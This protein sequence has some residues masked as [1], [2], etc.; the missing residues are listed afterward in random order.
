MSGSTSGANSSASPAR[1]P[2]VGF[3][4]AGLIGT[5][6]AER[7][8]RDRGHLAVVARANAGTARLLEAGARACPTPRAVADE[9]SVVFA[10]L[11]SNRVFE[12]VMLGAQ[13][14]V[15]GAAVRT[16]VNLGTSGAEFAIAMAERLADAGIDLLD[17]PVTGGVPGARSGTLT[18]MVSGPS[19][20]FDAVLPLLR[21]FAGKV[22]FVAERPGA[23][24]TLKVV[25]NLLSATAFAV[26]TE[27]LLMGAKSGLDPRLMLDVINAGSG[28]NSA[29]A[30]KFPRTVLS[31]TLEVG[32]ST[33]TI[34]K[35]LAL[36]VSEAEACGTPAW[37]A[38]V[39]RQYFLYSASRGDP[40]QDLALLV[41]HLEALAGARL[42]PVGETASLP[43]AP[44]G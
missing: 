39:V 33:A 44:A 23:A 40:A 7:L 16:V 25:N 9:A 19:P 34:C 5:P 15:G 14:V 2:G 37:I 35:D 10:C 24:Q 1:S 12:E 29:T 43:P 30:D 27:A 11:P 4:G 17:A 21:S 13:G 8:L 18:V 3:L 31:G 20:A 26:T 6:M 22:T 38:N 41:R 28:R 32:A 36:F 42:G